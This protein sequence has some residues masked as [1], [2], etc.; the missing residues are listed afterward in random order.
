MIQDEIRKA[1]SAHGGWK[2]KL[3]TI[4]ET[5]Q[6]EVTVEHVRADNNCAFGK[7]L[8]T[9]IEPGYK[10]SPHYQNALKLHAEF[11]VEAAK[12][13]AH[14]IKGEKEQAFELMSLSSDF[15]QISAKLT[16]ELSTWLEELGD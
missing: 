14:G 6:S 11:H 16:K 15:T 2:N 9:R 7:W 3:R 10:Q 1:I 8:H 5:G 13:L 4:A 12:V